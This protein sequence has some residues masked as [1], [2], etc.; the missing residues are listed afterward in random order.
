MAEEKLRK[1][2]EIA[3]Q[4]LNAKKLDDQLIDYLNEIDDLVRAGGGE[5]AS[6]QAIAVAIV[7]WQNSVIEDFTEYND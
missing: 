6:R 5:F 7:E 3:M 4:M 1:C 2:C